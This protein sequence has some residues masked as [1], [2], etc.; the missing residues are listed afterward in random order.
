M[1]LS[2]MLQQGYQQPLG[3]VLGATNTFPTPTARSA[4]AY[5]RSPNDL[6]SSRYDRHDKERHA[7]YFAQQNH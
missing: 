4:L 5:V 1:S 7:E 6:I 2:L 3:R